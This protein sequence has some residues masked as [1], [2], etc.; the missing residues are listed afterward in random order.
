MKI[1]LVKRDEVVNSIL[2]KMNSGHKLT[3]SDKRLL[4]DMMNGK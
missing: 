2:D 4:K 1:K 3:A